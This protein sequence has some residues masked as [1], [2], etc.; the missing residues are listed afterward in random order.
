MPIIQKIGLVAFDIN[1]VNGRH[2][3][4][5]EKPKFKQT[6]KQSEYEKIMANAILPE[7]NKVKEPPAPTPAPAQPVAPAPGRTRAT[8]RR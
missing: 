1:T 5:T 7:T 8:E 3:L 2:V 4:T 6:L